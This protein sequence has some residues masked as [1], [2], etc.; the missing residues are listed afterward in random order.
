MVCGGAALRYHANMKKKLLTFPRDFLWGAAT[1]SYQV[2]GGI[3]NND[4]AHAARK[5]WVPPCGRACD[6]YH[7]FEEDFDLAKALGH[8]SHRFSLEWARIEPEEG[9]F[10]EKALDHYRAVIAALRARGITPFITLWHFTLPWWFARRGGFERPDAPRYF[11]RYARCVAEALKESGAVH[12]ATMNEPLVFASLGWLRGK[13]PP[14]K[15]TPL[16]ERAAPASSPA[17]RARWRNGVMY[18]RVLHNLVRAHRRA[19]AAVKEVLPDASVGLVKNTI[20]FDHD[21]RWHH[22]AAAALLH[23]WWTHWFMRRVAPYCDAIGVN[24]YFYKKFCDTRR[25]EKSDMGWDLCPERIED[26]LVAM[27]R[28]G[29]PL[30]VAEGG[31]ADEEDRWR[32]DYIRRQVRGVHR[33]REKGAEVFAHHY[34]SLLDNYEWAEGFTKRFGLVAMDYETLARHPRPSAYAYKAICEAGAVEEE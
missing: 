9:V 14:F 25:Y 12:F 33:A 3:E 31:L 29:K 8:T 15:R 32:A 22:R 27:A 20:V 24:Y 34:W 6:H 21:G 17:L 4:W 18:V 10:D 28:Y 16:I 11:A 19:Y 2:E 13:W 23:W 30:Y 26:A 5:G 1:A 7:R